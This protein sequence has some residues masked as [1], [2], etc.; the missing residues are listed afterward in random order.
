MRKVLAIA[1]M[2]CIGFVVGCG[3]TKKTVDKK[4]TKTT[5]TTEKTTEKT[6]EKK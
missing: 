1:L 2:L 5:T 3:E 4:E 6:P